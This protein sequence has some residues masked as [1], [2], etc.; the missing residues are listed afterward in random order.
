MMSTWTILEVDKVSMCCSDAG[1]CNVLIWLVMLQGLAYSVGGGWDSPIDHPG[2]FVAG[3]ETTAPARF[4]NEL[5][6]VLQ[7]RCPSLP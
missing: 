5:Q 3:G 1:P 4:L 2:L 6:R 7:V